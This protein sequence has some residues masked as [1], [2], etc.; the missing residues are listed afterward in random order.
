VPRRAARRI[1]TARCSECVGVLAWRTLLMRGWNVNEAPSSDGRH[2][3][4]HAYGSGITAMPLN[5]A[6]M[7]TEDRVKKD[8]ACRQVVPADALNVD[9]VAWRSPRRASSNGPT[10]TP[11][12]ELYL[13]GRKQDLAFRAA[14]R[15]Q[16]APTSSRSLLAFG[17]AGRGRTPRVGRRATRPEGRLSDTTGQITHYTPLRIDTERDKLFATFS[18]RA[19]LAEEYKLDGFIQ[20][21]GRNGGGDPWHTMDVGGRRDQV[22][23]QAARTSFSFRAVR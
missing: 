18:T 10:M 3:A 12:A 22:L 14:C 8:H 16:S 19:T 15:R 7:D 21:R 17:S 1:R 4:P 20:F 6:L 11:R 2:P 13:W 23:V 5:V 9:A